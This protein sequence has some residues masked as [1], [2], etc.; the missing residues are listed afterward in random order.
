M[1][2]MVGGRFP[3]TLVIHSMVGGRF[4]PNINVNMND[5]IERQGTEHLCVHTH[6]K[7]TRQWMFSM[8]A[9]SVPE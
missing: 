9:L 2:S 4:Y 7:E 8:N 1:H 5:V 3:P 6:N